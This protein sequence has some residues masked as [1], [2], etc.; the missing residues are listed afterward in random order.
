MSE[1]PDAE[2]AIDGWR[3]GIR[4]AASHV[5]P[6]HPKCGH[7]H[8]HTYSVSCKLEGEVPQDGMIL[9]FG[10]VKDEIRELA[11][12]L[13]HRW[14]LPREPNSGEVTVED[15]TVVYEVGDKRHVVPES[16]V[17]FVDI[18]VCT[19]EFLANMFADRLMKQVDFPDAVHE[20]Q[21]GIDEGHGKGAWAKRTP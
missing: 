12:E 16:D 1:G 9:D 15:G 17:A 11:E 5:V 14:M 21:I 13:D 20:V 4:F 18:P 6:H 3:Q 7:L 19:A 10:V 8:G 2:L